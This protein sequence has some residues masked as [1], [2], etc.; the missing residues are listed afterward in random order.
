MAKPVFID[1]TAFVALNSPI[2]PDHGKAVDYVGELMSQT[3]RVITNEW[4]VALAANQ[5]KEKMGPDASTR[6][7][8]L[9][10]EGGVVILPM[11]D[12]I[13]D[14]AEALFLQSEHLVDLSYTDC[15]HVAFMEHY[16]ITNMFTFKSHMASMNVI[17]VPK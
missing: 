3:V 1:E 5:L 16:Q 11:K 4:A 2:A 14:H 6:F 12:G 7:L 8:K 15:I 9:L 13:Y 10:N 17:A